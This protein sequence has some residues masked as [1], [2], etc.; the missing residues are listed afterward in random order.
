M[1]DNDTPAGDRDIILDSITEGVF[2]VGPDWR[3]RSFNRAA[4]EITGVPRERALG[5][6]CRQIL[7]AEICEGRCALAETMRDGRPIVGR[8]VTILDAG[9]ERKRISINT[10][11]LRDAG[12]NV[13]GG[14]ETFRDVSRLDRL[15]RELSRRYRLG[16]IVS[17]SH[18]MREL[19]EIVPAV[20]DSL[21]T[22]L[23]TGESGT[24]KE[25]LARAVHGTGPRSEGPFVAVNCG[26]LPDTLLE[27]EL[28]GY[29]RGAFTGAESDRPGRFA[30]AEG[31]TLFLDE[32]GDISPAMQTRLLRFLQERVYE[33]LG[34]SGSVRADVRVIAATNRDL[35]EL[36]AEGGFR[37]DLY[38]RV[39]VVRL[40]IPPLRERMEDVPLLVEHFIE[41]FNDTMDRDVTGISDDALA[42]LMSYDF[43]GNVRELE[44]IVERAFVLCRSGPLGVEHLPGRVCG[45]SP[46]EG[47][48]GREAMR[49]MEAAFLMRAL[50]RN[51]WS[52]TRTAEEL[53]VHRT[54][55]SRRIRALGLDVPLPGG[56]RRRRDAG[57]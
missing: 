16:D 45:L 15:R 37:E 47:G 54:T 24:G 5:Q 14:V 32:V 49:R 50:R 23:I 13:V 26:A 29:V 42:C 21:S 46:A 6:P 20:A 18:G 31:G 33:P 41:R 10:A 2:T 51:D 12:G 52:R 25:L 55:V 30:A 7:R 35:E 3:I 8:R 40:D 9:G 44:N 4:E 53:G 43:P 19:F 28:F 11:L 36:V 22:L 27:S 1:Q 48:G 57:A 56:R 38:Y 17:R 39:N 34:S